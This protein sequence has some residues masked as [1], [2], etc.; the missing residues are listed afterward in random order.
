ML[1]L[2][3][4]AI[5]ATRRPSHA[6][7]LK[8]AERV[9]NGGFVQSHHRIAIVFLIAGVNQG[10]EGQRVIVGRGDVFLDQRSE[11]ASLDIAQVQVRIVHWLKFNSLNLLW[12]Q[13][14]SVYS[15]RLSSSAHVRAFVAL[16]AERSTIRRHADET[17]G[18]HHDRRLRDW[19]SLGWRKDDRACFRR[20]CTYAEIQRGRYGGSWQH[21]HSH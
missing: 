5:G 2:S 16:E 9:P 11:D 18:V 1:I 8:R 3:D 12:P 17:Q 4:S 19:R 10:I 14:A 7:F 6:P 15:S 20:A 13:A 21:G